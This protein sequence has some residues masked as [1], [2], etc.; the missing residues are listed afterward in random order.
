MGGSSFE[1][2]G[3]QTAAATN[4]SRPRN[5]AMAIGARDKNASDPQRL[6]GP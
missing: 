3:E 2:S 1:I 5:W 4:Q 6:S